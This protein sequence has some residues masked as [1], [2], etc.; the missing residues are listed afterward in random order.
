MQKLDRD[1]LRR[2][3]GVKTVFQTQ[4]SAEVEPASQADPL[5]PDA[6]GLADIGIDLV[7]QLRVSNSVRA[8]G[9]MQPWTCDVSPLRGPGNPKPPVEQEGQQNDA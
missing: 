9:F 6:P 8:A 7:R 2:C 1:V 4:A 5:A 3:Y